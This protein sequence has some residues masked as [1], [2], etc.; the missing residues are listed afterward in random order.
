MKK[1]ITT[2]FLLILSAQA[3][4]CIISPLYDV[5]M[6]VEKFKKK[7]DLVFFGKLEQTTLINKYIHASNFTIIKTYKG[8]ASKQVT[9]INKLH[10]SCSRPFSKV[11]TAYY[12]FAN[13]TNKENEFI[14]DGYA[15]FV[16]LNVAIETNMVLK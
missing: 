15:T 16:P 11:G 9:I 4:A 7:A 5:A 14:I 13:K 1:S 8:K 6:N 10:S 2:I 12:V 3:Y